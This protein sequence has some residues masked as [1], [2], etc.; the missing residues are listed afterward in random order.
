MANVQNVFELN[1]KKY[2][3]LTG[4]ML[5]K[6]T[7]S[8]FKH[9]FTKT[10]QNMDGFVK[11]TVKKT[12][13]ANLHVPTAHSKTL[14]RSAV[15][16]PK[17]L[18]KSLPTKTIQAAQ[19]RNA[20]DDKR[21]KRASHVPKSNLVSKFGLSGF[22]DFNLK[23]IFK[24]LE[25]KA[26]PTAFK[27]KNTIVQESSKTVTDLS[28][29]KANAHLNKPPKKAR[30]HHRAAQRLNISPKILNIGMASL[31]AILIA[32]FITYQNVPRIAVRVA[33]ARAGVTAS[34]PDYIPAGFSVSGH[35]Q[36]KP[37]QIEIGYKSNSDNRLFHISQ[38]SSAWD[39]QA[40][41]ENFVTLNR[42]AYQTYEDKGKTIYI[43]DGSSATW[44]DR[45]VWFQ[46]D[47]NSSL[48]SDQL[49]RLADSM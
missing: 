32:G 9:S 11:N 46:I 26:A 47:G 20:L 1:G 37:G 45:G 33:A 43:Y 13:A 8:Q 18:H 19:Q 6:N 22:S 29:K 31:A 12:V 35:I 16:K 17:I 10:G 15:K 25:V 34:L 48:N 5:N 27:S 24:D 40:L 7:A 42:R 14:M 39:S 23:P 36:Y 38:S 4:K 41:L 21:L 28:L 44:V 30:L 3:A 2:D 49:L